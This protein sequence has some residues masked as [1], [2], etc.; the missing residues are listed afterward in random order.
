VRARELLENWFDIRGR[1]AGCAH[2]DCIVCEENRRIIEETK[3]YLDE[4][5]EGING[6]F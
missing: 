4:T 1:L 6:E 2:K 5:K 3:K